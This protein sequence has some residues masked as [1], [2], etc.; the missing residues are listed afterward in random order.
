MRLAAA[1]IAACLVVSACA[2]PNNV[3]GATSNDTLTF[4]VGPSY[5]PTPPID[6]T[7]ETITFEVENNSPDNTSVSDIP[8]VINRDGVEYSSGTI[9]TIAPNATQNIIFTVTESDGNPHTYEVV[10]DPNDQTGAI[11]LTS[12][13]QSVTIDWQPSADG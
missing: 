2:P 4:P 10:L 6:G 13:T 8:Y 9:A 3:S 11:N 1:Y 12:N 5:M 7:T